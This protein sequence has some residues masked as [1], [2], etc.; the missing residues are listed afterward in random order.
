MSLIALS[1]VTLVGHLADKETVLADL[2][3]M[4][5]LE[6]IPLTAPG[7]A[8]SEASVRPKAREA[9]KFLL[10]YPQRRRQATDAS[11]F[12]AEAV[13]RQALELEQRLHA[14]EEEHDF[15][16]QRLDALRPWGAFEFPPLEAM[17]GQRLW[18]Y[19]VPHKDMKQVEATDLNWQAVGR[20]NRFAYV[21]VVSPDEPAGMPVPRVHLG[22]RP[23]REL[24]RRL[25]EV[26]LAI[27]DAQAE[28]AWLTRWCLLLARSLYRLEDNAVRANAL[29]QTYDN[30]P[31]FALQGWAPKD[32]LGDLGAYADK[33]GLLLEATDPA[34]G[35]RPP[36]LL[37]N[38]PPISAGEDLVNFYMTPGY[39]TWDPSSVLF[40]SF[41]LFFAM[42][43]ADAGYAALL[44]L[45]LAYLWSRMGRSDAGRRFRS[46]GLA[47]L[48]A[49][50]VYGVVV[51]S[52]FGL[53]PS[54][55]S[56][57]G[58]LHLLHMS[59][60][61]TMMA[62]SVVIGA[63][64]VILGN[65]MD[66][67]RYGRDPR[68]LA[69]VG[70]A[71]L[72]AGGLLLGG[73]VALKM[74]WLGDVGKGLMVLGVALVVLFAGAGLPPLKRLGHGLLDLHRITGAFGDVLSYLRLFALGLASASVAVGFNDMA[75][76]IKTGLPGLGLL[77]A[78]LVLL[79]GHTLNL[80]IGVSGG[81]IHGMRLNVIEFFNW[82]LKEE[83]RLYQPFKRSEDTVWNR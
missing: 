44:G 15:L 5:C 63:G 30:D 20:D 35:D 67:W 24:E 68:A 42:I 53:E 37:R 74:T 47:M 52:Y 55:H 59:D 45:L 56:L 77:L 60:A 26:E 38:P 9:L 11:R 31:V 61:N 80:L 71:C 25:E 49:S 76:Q 22:A 16:V 2:Q 58:H 43:L 8:A 3:G 75:M 19:V 82:G 70:W 13:A 46:L 32:R 64:H 72:V 48:L 57:L 51:G 23:R 73:G 21:A 6:L 27:E 83:G 81:V 39:R 14:L 62:I 41:T 10:T 28:R 50:L 29:R 4:G 17:G 34:P 78:L 40:F 7:E 65:L 36:T 12:D 18:F 79:I 66:A 1:R 69:P 33:H 54:P